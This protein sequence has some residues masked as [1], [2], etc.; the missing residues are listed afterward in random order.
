MLQRQSSP[1]D[2]RLKILL[3]QRERKVP[4]LLPNGHQTNAEVRLVAR[5]LSR[6]LRRLVRPAKAEVS[7]VAHPAGAEVRLVVHRFNRRLKLLLRQLRPLLR[8]LRL[9]LPPPLSKPPPQAQRP[10]PTQTHR[11]L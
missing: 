5:K 8:Q 1:P 11:T 2:L 10:S 9:L 6:L 3:H 7:P 4:L